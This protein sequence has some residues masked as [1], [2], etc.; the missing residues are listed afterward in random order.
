MSLFV[1]FVKSQVNSKQ[2]LKLKHHKT[3]PLNESLETSSAGEVQKTAAVAV[4]E[5]GKHRCMITSNV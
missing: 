1:A 5:D 3:A 4:T 2:Q